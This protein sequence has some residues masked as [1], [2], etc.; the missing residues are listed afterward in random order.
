MGGRR[1]FKLGESPENAHHDRSPTDPN[2]MITEESFLDFKCPHC[3]EP[4]SFPESAVGFVQECP[5]CAESLIVPGPGKEIGRNLPLPILTPRLKLRRFTAGDWK[6]LLELISLEG[7]WV[8][9]MPG[10]GEEEVLRWL[11]SDSHIR[12]TTPNQ[13]FPLALELQ[14]GGGLIG[15]LGLWFTDALRLQAR[16]IL[17]LH[18]N[19]QHKGLAREAL[20]GVLGFCFEGIQ[21]H[22]VAASCDSKNTAACRLC[23]QV[24]MRREGEFV[25]DLCLAGGEWANSVWYAALAENYPGSSSA[26]K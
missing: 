25:K 21:L 18:P 20:N 11:E 10:E 22:R 23:E 12:L 19:H 17:S 14:D 2:A 13:M 16:V 26:P 5:G 1:K 3:G 7:T 24:G 6:G 15:Y 4:V 8:E 9:G